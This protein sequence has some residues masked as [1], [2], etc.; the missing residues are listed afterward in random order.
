MGGLAG[1]M[2]HLWEDLDMTFGELE[3][4]VSEATSGDLE[5]VEKFDGVNIFFSLDAYS[6]VR[7]A[8][9][10]EHVQAGG[11]KIREAVKL[12]DRHPARDQFVNGFYA[13]EEMCKLGW[14][15]LG[16]SRKNWVNSEI[17]YALKPQTIKYATNAIVLHEAVAFDKKGKRTNVDVSEQFNK[18]V[19]NTDKHSVVTENQEWLCLGPVNVFLDNVNGAGFLT[20][21]ISNLNM[22]RESAS[23]NKD[24]TLREWAYF[25]LLSGPLK[26]FNISLERKEKI[27]RLILE[28]DADLRLI[29]LKKGVS[30]SWAAQISAIGAKKNRSKVMTETMRPV[31][32]IIARVGAQILQNQTSHLV[33]N[34]MDQAESLMLAKEN[35]VLVAESTNDGFKNERLNIMNTYVKILDI[36][37]TH[38]PAM[39]GVVFSRGDKKY[40]LTGGFGALNQIIG[41]SRYGRGKIPP[42]TL[43]KAL[44]EDR[45]NQAIFEAFGL[46]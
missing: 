45:K 35:S 19:E 32:A 46:V 22:V 8:R 23:L 7:F 21:F 39:E 9:N 14:W 34:P 5:V 41:L 28:M 12:F 30:K 20:D 16:F 27:A 40:K 29:D 10:Q 17:V 13:I 11:L 4:I 25:S 38:I 3:E 43:E 36:V 44:Q 18:L 1:H 31:E 2:S 6:N 37:D 15:P 26:S 42:V 33:E 24:S